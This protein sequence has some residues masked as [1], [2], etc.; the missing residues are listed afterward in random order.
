M[1][2]FVRIVFL[3]DVPHEIYFKPCQ[4]NI[5]MRKLTDTQRLSKKTIETTTNKHSTPIYHSSLIF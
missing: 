1:L 4:L 2:N 3:F 5:L